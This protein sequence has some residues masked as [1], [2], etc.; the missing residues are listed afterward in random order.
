M[1]NLRESDRRAETEEQK[2]ARKEFAKQVAKETIEEFLNQIY[3]HVGKTVVERIFLMALSALV[4]WYLTS[5]GMIPPLE[6][7][8]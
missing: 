8:K 6:N 7:L 1:T 3:H 5:K 4:T 2:D